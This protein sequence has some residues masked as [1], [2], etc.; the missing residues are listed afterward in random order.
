MFFVFN[1]YTVF[2][3]SITLNLSFKLM[4]QK[5]FFFLMVGLLL[6]ACSKEEYE[7]PYE[8][9]LEQKDSKLILKFVMPYVMN[10]VHSGDM[11]NT[12]LKFRLISQNNSDL[13]TVRTRFLPDGND[14]TNV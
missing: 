11:A 4:R 8:S 14:K 2:V 12:W 3:Q 13:M 10:R 7:N 1:K 5:I 6:S 9:T